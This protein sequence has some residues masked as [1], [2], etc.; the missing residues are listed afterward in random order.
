MNNKLKVVEEIVDVFLRAEYIKKISK[1]GQDE[2]VDQEIRESVLKILNSKDAEEIINYPETRLI[3]YLKI[4]LDSTYINHIAQKKYNYNLETLKKIE[5]SIKNNFKEIYHEWEKNLLL[6]N[7]YKHYIVNLEPQ[8]EEKVKK[9]S[10]LSSGNPFDLFKLNSLDDLKGSLV[11]FK[12]QHGCYQL[13]SKNRFDVFEKNFF[14]DSI[15]YNFILDTIGE[16][17]EYVAGKVKDFSTRN[18]NGI[19][20]NAQKGTKI[21]VLTV[22][23]H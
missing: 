4:C 10:S 1:K 3:P 6:S 12:Q 13:Y 8:K 7:Y 21:V 23:P 14:L 15:Q 9:F 16:N 17:I 2:E 19:L 22:E 20:Y 5:D 18:S 11:Y